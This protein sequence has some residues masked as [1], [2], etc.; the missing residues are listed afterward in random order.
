MAAQEFFSAFHDFDHL[1]GNAFV[2]QPVVEALFSIS[3]STLWRLVRRGELPAPQRLSIRA[4]GWRVADLREA[5]AKSISVR[6]TGRHAHRQADG[7][8]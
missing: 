5:L 1:P 7:N 6:P 3:A 4:V 8:G 2:R